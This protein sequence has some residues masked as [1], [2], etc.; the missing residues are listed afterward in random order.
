MIDNDN[1]KA[2]RQKVYLQALVRISQIHEEIASGSFPSVKQLAEK[3]KVNERTIKRD[4]DVLRDQLNAPIIY[5]RKKKG[6]RYSEVGW[7]FLY[8]ISMKKNFSLFLLQKMLLN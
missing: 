4:L 5:E 3:T 6:F 7:S 8:Q 2:S 1:P